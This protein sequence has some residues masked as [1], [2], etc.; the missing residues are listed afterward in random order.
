MRKQVSHQL[1]L[2]PKTNIALWP[3]LGGDIVITLGKFVPLVAGSPASG[4]M[5]P[6]PDMIVCGQ[7][8]AIFDPVALVHEVRLLCTPVCSAR[9]SHCVPALSQMGHNF[10]KRMWGGVLANARAYACALRNGYG[11]RRAILK[12]V[13]HVVL[14]YRV[15]RSRSLQRL[16]HRGQI[17]L[18]H[19]RQQMQLWVRRA[20]NAP[21][22]AL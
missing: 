12:R 18:Q 14:T 4:D 11:R 19:R 15:R 1:T 7:R 2:T 17:L 9:A 16:Q 20:R 8:E 21:L 5:G 3:K 6:L 10:G 22:H 13:V